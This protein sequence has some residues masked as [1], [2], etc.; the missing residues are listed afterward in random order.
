MITPK[1]IS[2]G[3]NEIKL[4]DEYAKKFGLNRSAV[5]RYVINDFFLKNKGASS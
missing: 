4:I 3:E 1:S 5:V 2:L